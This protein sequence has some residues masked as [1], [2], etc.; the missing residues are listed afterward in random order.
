MTGSAI[1]AYALLTMKPTT[2]SLGSYSL[3]GISALITLP[4]SSSYPM[5]NYQLFTTTASSFESHTLEITAAE[6]G[7][8]YLDYILLETETAFV[9]SSDA[10]SGSTSGESGTST[11]TGVGHSGSEGTNVGAI[12]GGVVGGLSILVLIGVAVFWYRRRKGW[13]HRGVDVAAE[14]EWAQMNPVRRVEGGQ[15]EM[16][17]QTLMQQRAHSSRLSLDLIQCYD[18]RIRCTF[19]FLTI[20]FD[21]SLHHHTDTIPS[22]R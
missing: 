19:R 14:D 9:A 11:T 6:A 18:P 5:Y 13:K 7:V 17:R 20:F 21:F 15:I 1:R 12:A 16:A 8:F 10:L 3:D 22:D 4:T 2:S